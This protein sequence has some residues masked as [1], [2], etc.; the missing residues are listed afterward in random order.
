M[1]TT[2]AFGSFDLD[3]ARRLLRKSGEPVAIGGKAFDALVY[4]LE[5][6][7]RV[8]TR[9]E[10]ASALWPTT[11]VEDNNL[12][13]TVQALRRAL[14]DVGPEHVYVV[15]VPRRGYQFVGDVTAGCNRVATALAHGEVASRRTCFTTAHTGAGSEALPARGLA[16]FGRSVV[17][18]TAGISIAINL[19]F[20]AA[21][22]MLWNVHRDRPPQEAARAHL[23]KPHGAPAEAA[24]WNAERDKRELSAT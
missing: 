2:Y 23:A 3:S 5:H 14:G 4:L 12:S 8:V 16:P 22:L 9:K 13:Q 7:G 17:L 11:V 19:L 21:A 20:F 18:V 6:A 24:K 10:L 1:Q 15:T